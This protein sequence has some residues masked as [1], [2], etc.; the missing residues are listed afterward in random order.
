LLLDALW[1]VAPDHTT[2]I[3]VLREN[4]SFWENLVGA[5]EISFD[6][7]KH[8]Q[9]VTTECYTTLVKASIFRILTLEL[10]YVPVEA[11][12]RLDQSLAAQ[13]KKLNTW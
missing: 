1:Q 6:S 10:Y 5:L 4:P 11:S 13:F 2:I 9:D 12:N 8:V 3:K 7:L